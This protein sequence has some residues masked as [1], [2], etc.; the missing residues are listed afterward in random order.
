LTASEAEGR[1]V[2]WPCQGRALPDG[3]VTLGS[4]DAVIGIHGPLGDDSEI[5]TT[6][7]RVSHGCIRLHD[8]ALMR[9]SKVPAGTPI[10]IVR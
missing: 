6:G 5:G 7:A 2:S 3:D 8:R 1:R 9:L 10:D 4:G